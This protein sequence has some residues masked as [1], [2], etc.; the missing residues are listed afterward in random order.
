MAAELLLP[1]ARAS[2]TNNSPYNGA[3][4][5]FYVSGTSTPQ[6]VYA[7]ADLETS[8][9]STVT[10][11]GAGKFVP[12]YMDGTKSYRGV[13]KNASGSV[14]LHDIDPINNGLNASGN[15]AFAPPGAD[16]VTRTLESKLR[17]IISITDYGASPDASAATN[18]LAFHRAMNYHLNRFPNDDDYYEGGPGDPT[19]FYALD[20]QTGKIYV[21]AG[22]YYVPPDVFS[23]LTHARAPYVGFEFVGDGKMSSILMLETGGAEAWFYD[24][25]SANPL[26]F[27]QMHW[28]DIGFR[29]DDYLYG[30]V[31]KMYSTG[32]P[33][34]PRWTDCDFQYLQRFFWAEGTGNADLVKVT[35]CTGMFY[36]TM[37]AFDNDQSVQIDFL[38][39]D[40]GTYGNY[41]RVLEHG[42]G[43]VTIANAS[44]D[45][46][47][48]EGYSP[49]TGNFLFQH[50]SNSSIG[51]GNSMFKFENCRFEIE[52]YTTKAGGVATTNTAGYAAGVSSVTLAAGGSG[53][54]AIGAKLYFG[55]DQTEYTTTSAVASLAA[56][57]AVSFTPVLAAS[58]PAAATPVSIN[59]P[60]FGLVKMVENQNAI[61]YVQFDTCTFVNGQTYLLD[62][63][64]NATLDGHRRIYAVRMWPAKYVEFRNC[65]ML[66][67]F[68]YNFSG[69][70]TTNS[71]PD[72]GVVLLSRCYDGITTELPTADAALENIHSRANYA[73][74]AGRLITEGTRAH[75]T[76]TSN[77]RKLLDAD[78][79]WSYSFAREPSC[80]KKLVHFKHISNG[81]PSATSAASVNGG[82]DH[83]LDIPPGMM[84][85]RIYVKKL[86]VGGGSTDAYQL[87]IKTTD[88]SG[89]I[90]GSSTS[91]RGEFKDEHV[92]DLSHVDLTGISRLCLCASG[93]WDSFS[94]PA[95]AIAYIEY[96]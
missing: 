11:D 61:P 12:I 42:G 10:A 76:G 92:I 15:I 1:T 82:L 96:V 83:F 91:A 95:V 13:C 65:V 73:G 33:K 67:N 41:I 34:Q 62:G 32:G 70:R 49:S 21:P 72:G 57:G 64:G 14:T 56:G 79:R 17:E 89:T 27:Q 78:P 45:F 63:S 85:L 58:I 6:S 71:P 54:I 75:T 52:A 3:K 47:Y 50:E 59:P 51:A 68:F 43:N 81:W 30:N 93:A 22:R 5:F 60:P 36:G 44:I 25:T 40:L 35:R 74:S 9:G 90:L 38:G 4:W 29:A 88:R 94:A 46:I 37:L 20:R 31:C 19:D 53:A 77:V 86:A 26:Q 16:A 24:N 39:S 69:S 7:D 55:T 87:H 2:D 28:K 8:L 48:R 18:G 80:S 23:S 66:K 84:A